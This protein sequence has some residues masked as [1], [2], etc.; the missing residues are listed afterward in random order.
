MDPLPTPFTKNDHLNSTPEVHLTWRTPCLGGS[1]ISPCRI[2]SPPMPSKKKLLVNFEV[3]SS[4]VKVYELFP[5][6]IT[7]SNLSGHQARDIS[8]EVPLPELKE[9]QIPFT[10]LSKGT[11]ASVGATNSSS[12]IGNMAGSNSFQTN[13]LSPDRNKDRTKELLCKLLGFNSNKVS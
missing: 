1:M 7:V 6:H 4:P 10:L 5:V 8:I 11:S 12:T 9:D 13:A 3:E 2:P